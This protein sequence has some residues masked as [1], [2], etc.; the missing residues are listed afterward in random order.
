[1]DLDRERA[2]LASTAKAFCCRAYVETAAACIQV[3]GAV[4]FTWEHEASL[5]LKR[6]KSSELLFGDA[7]WHRRRVARLLGL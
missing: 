5:H 3:H 2:L 6:A 1:A 4:G 7:A